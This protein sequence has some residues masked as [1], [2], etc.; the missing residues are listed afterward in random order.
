MH[1]HIGHNTTE[2]RSGEST[3]KSSE[4]KHKEDIFF[5]RCNGEIRDSSK[6]LMESMKASDDMKMALLISMQ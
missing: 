4:S 2:Q 1:G 5:E 3:S 6:S